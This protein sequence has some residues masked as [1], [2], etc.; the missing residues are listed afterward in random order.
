M[1]V[2]GGRFRSNPRPRYH[3]AMNNVLDRELDRLRAMTA[4]EKIAVMNSLWWQAWAL[5][6]AAVRDLHPD[7][8]PDQVTAAVREIFRGSGT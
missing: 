3:S 6:T 5:K 4:T 1:G 8:A 2:A 7:W